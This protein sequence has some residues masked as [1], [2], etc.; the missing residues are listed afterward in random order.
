M[1]KDQEKEQLKRLL[2]SKFATI[3]S[4]EKCERRK[5]KNV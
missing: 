2:K 5:G 1:D 3:K 4:L